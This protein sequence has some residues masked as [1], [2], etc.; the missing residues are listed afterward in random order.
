MV[1]EENGLGLTLWRSNAVKIG[2]KEK[3]PAGAGILGETENAL[4][5]EYQVGHINNAL[6]F[7]CKSGL[8]R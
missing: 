3:I 5:V 7:W 4:L 6:F 1:L 2:V 8:F